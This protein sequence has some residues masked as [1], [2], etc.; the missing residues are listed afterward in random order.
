MPPS[1]EALTTA[2]LALALEAGARRH[3]VLAANIANAQTDGYRALH[4]RFASGLE[5]ARQLVRERG[6]VDA[7]A[8]AG[9]RIEVE[10][11]QDAQGLPLPVQLDAQMAEVSRNAVQYQ[12]LVQALSRHFAI[13]AAA[14]GD[15]RK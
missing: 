4:V 15:G 10:P 1:V 13:L 12:T 9:I 2:T 7:A 11:Q 5:E 14:V 3:E 6:S 8:L